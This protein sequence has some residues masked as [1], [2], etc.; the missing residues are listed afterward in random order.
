MAT[1]ARALTLMLAAAA[2]AALI[3]AAAERTWTAGRKELVVV[4]RTDGLWKVR[5]DGS[6]AARIP[7]TRGAKR[8]SWSPDGRR[9]AF[10]RGADLFVVNADGTGLRPLSARPR[11]VEADP[12]WAPDGRTVAFARDGSIVVARHNGA[13]ARVVA[14]TARSRDPAWSP[15]GRRIAYSSDGDLFVVRARR[16]TPA[17]LT[18]RP[19]LEQAPA[20]SPDGRELA[21]TAAGRIAVIRADG[22]NLRL[23][24]LEPFDARPA[25]S[26]QG[27]EIAFERADGGVYAV[28][29][30]GVARRVT[31]GAAPAWRRVP[32]SAELLPDLDQRAPAGVT[33]S[34]AG[35]R[36]RL[37][38]ASAV[39]NVGR[40]SVWIRGV[41]DG[42]GGMRA[43]QLVTLAAGGVERNLAVGRLR[44]TASPDHSHWH[45][46]QFERYEL[47][48][49]RDFALV[50]SDRK[51]GFCL[52]DHYGHALQVRPV[53]PRF[54]GN[55]GP[56][57]VRLRTVD[58]GSS[59]GYTD[60][61]PA[62]F[63]GQYVDVTRVPSGVYY[64][65]HRANPS[66]LLRELSYR[67]NAASVRIQ[68]TRGTV[69]VLRV[70]HGAERC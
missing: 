62:H 61:Y 11:S 26:P 32:T 13:G 68:L 30:D 12:A 28:R 9:I 33:L 38:F 59:V 60:R 8:P 5:P 50:A 44:Y 24:T 40:G 3:A 49:Q 66:N 31:S 65:V 23:L 37:A 4:A 16:G 29:L 27:D 69:R 70:C 56:G 15:D 45:L 43:D 17:R 2:G 42:R 41:R 55:C 25:W 35:G 46:M 14:R 52:A 39:D 22:S 67:N 51:T 48:R 7:R 21:F 58:Q 20:W 34:R 19:E 36:L 54:L 64:L 57:N 47:R 18:T 63:H 6:R 1:R 53:A 10:A